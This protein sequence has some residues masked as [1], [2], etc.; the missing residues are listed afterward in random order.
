MQGER[1]GDQ[2]AE[3]DFEIR[4]EREGYDDRDGVGV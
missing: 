4:D 2:L 1:F 3:Q